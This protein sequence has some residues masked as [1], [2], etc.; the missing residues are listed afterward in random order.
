MSM[1]DKMMEFMMG[2]MSK[3][4]KEKMMDKFFADMTADDRRKM[5]AQ[6]MPKMMEAM[7]TMMGMMSRM[8]GSGEKMEMPMMHQMMAEM[9][10]QCL[11]M[12]LPDLTNEERIDF[13]AT[14]VDMFVEQCSAGMSEEEKKG[15]R[16]KLAERIGS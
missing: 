1:T 16:G 13:V 15:F 5:M 6:M 8:K 14:M 9:M 10:P 7:R 11:T 4:D 12:M 2:E 3:G